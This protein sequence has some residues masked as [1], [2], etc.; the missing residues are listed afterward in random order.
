MDF[1]GLI[2]VFTNMH[3]VQLPRSKETGIFPRQSVGLYIHVFLHAFVSHALKIQTP[4]YYR[5][6][7]NDLF[8]LTKSFSLDHT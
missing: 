5:R 4:C 1:F 3:S 7:S 2:K 6:K 8:L